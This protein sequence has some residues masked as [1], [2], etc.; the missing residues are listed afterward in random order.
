MWRL[1]RFHRLVLLATMLAP[2]P[3]A[4]WADGLPAAPPPAALPSAAPPAAEPAPDP[5]LPAEPPTPEPEIPG[6][7]P[8][9]AIEE[10]PQR[11]P[12]HPT[13]VDSG[14][15]AVAEGFLWSVDRLDHFFADEREVD[16][17]RPRSF[18]RWRNEVEARD[19]GTFAASTAVRAELLFPS[20]DRRLRALRLT[21]SGGT[22]D[23]LDQLISGQAP[24]PDAARRPTAGLRLPIF[25]ALFTQ[26]DLQAGLLFS[27]P[28]G[29]YTRLRLRHVQP[30][31]DVLLA[32]FALSGF[33]QTPTGWG[34]R[35]DVELER[36]LLSWLLL[37]LDGTGTVT[38]RSRGWE[39]ASEL[40]LLAAAGSRTAV[41]LGGGP[42]GATQAGPVVETWRAHTR[43]RRDVLRRW[44]FV[45]LEPAVAWQRPPGGGR[46]RTR[47]I[48]LRLEIQFDAAMYPGPGTTPPRVAAVPASVRASVRCR[49]P[50]PMRPSRLEPIGCGGAP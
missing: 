46:D 50:A 29:W 49:P 24:A 5:E 16:L 17:P 21:I 2:I 30:V 31:E 1:L 3:L 23:A 25:D 11:P 19:D 37:R 8:A 6:P 38:Q 27:L 22:N 42:A 35:Q 33:W 44:I 41:F 13:W 36:Q 20:L 9:P 14:H 32:R 48:I 45:E 7:A 40:S 15:S 34:T 28:I 47:S 26:T 4:A 12:G 43:V 10:A 39:W 18:V